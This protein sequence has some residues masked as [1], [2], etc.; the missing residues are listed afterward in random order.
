MN[1]STF[2]LLKKIVTITFFTIL[3]VLFLVLL[4]LTI[5]D[6]YI[7]NVKQFIKTD[8][9]VLYISNEKNYNK[10]P[11]SLLDKYEINYMYINSDKISKF[12]KNKIQK[13][14]NNKD[15]S[16]IIVIFE[17]GKIKDAL[18]SWDDNK[19]LTKFLIKNEVIPSIIENI[20]G[21]TNKILKAKESDSLILY[22]P[23]SYNENIKYQ[24]NL[25][26]DISKKYNIEYKK[27]DAYLL[28]K[29]QK[30]KINLAFEISNV[31]DQIVLFIKDKTVLGS[32]RGYNRKSDYINKLFEY[33]YVEEVNNSLNEIEYN[34]FVSK[35]NA[36]EENVILITKDDCKYC[37][38]VVNTLNQ[39]SSDNNLDI[40][41]I[42]VN[43]IDSQK[44]V[45]VENKLKELGYKDGFSTPLVIITEKGKVLDYV[46]GSS[47]SDY[48]KDM[49][50]EYGLLK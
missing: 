27:Y 48:F 40:D 5:D 47:T 2:E 42:N 19:K 8:T 3:V 39:I 14:V 30:E 50:T 28:S 36:E 33:N 12:E 29:T 45:D 16:N 32:L 13:I 34:E 18:I 44:S 46:I 6:K 22:L 9:K 15:L 23:Y 49:F 37:G 20:S 41:Y 43:D 35:I 24:D 26:K 4:I 11:K 10:Y 38:E 31:E 17:S 25:I 7:K 21:L 1:K